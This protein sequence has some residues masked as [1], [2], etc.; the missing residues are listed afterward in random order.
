MAHPIRPLPVVQAWDCHV[1]G[2]CCKEYLVTITDE[3]RQRIEEQGWDP[4]TDLGGLPPFRYSGWPWARK[5]HLNHRADGSCVFLG[6]GGKCR[7]HERFGYETKPLPCRLFPFVLVPA[8]DRWAVGLRFACPSVAEN[9]G[10]P[11]PQ[12]LRRGIKRIARHAQ[13]PRNQC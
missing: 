6:E 13:V 4:E 5:V 11:L 1:S 8:G 12:H 3:E 9:K 7:I 2:S 10:R